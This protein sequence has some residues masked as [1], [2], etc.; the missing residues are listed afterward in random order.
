M[1]NGTVSRRT[2]RTQLA[3]Q[4]RPVRKR[5]RLELLEDR[6]LLAFTVN[7]TPYL[8]LGDAALTGYDAG[9]D[10]VEVLWQT[11]G[12]QDT[13]TFTAQVRH[14]GDLAW[15][16]VSLN[17]DIVTGVS[18]RINHS[19]TLSGL[20]FDDNYDYLVTH[21][22]GGSPIATYQSTFHT[23]KATTDFGDYTFVTYGDSANGD[24]PSNFIAVQTRIKALNPA[25][26]LLLG[27]NVYSSGTHA[28]YDLRLDPSK[29]AA[30]TTYNKNH[31]DYFAFGNHDVGAAN[32]QAAL[33][34]YSMPIP[35]AGVTSPAGITFDAN[36]QAEKNYSY[37]YGGVHFLTFDTNN[38][39][40][41]A[42]LDKQLDW[43]VADINAAKARSTPPNWIIVFG[44]HPITSLGGHTEHTPDDYYY[45]QVLSRLGPSGVGV[46]LLLFGHAH[47][48]QRSYP[49]TGHT[50]ATAT[51][52]L[53]TDNNYA[54]GAGLPLVVQGTGGAD[55]G[56]YGASDATF[57]G[58][59]VAKAL[60]SNT[61]VAVQFGF[62]KVDVTA[63]RLTY[64]YVN[65]AGVVLDSF[66]IGTPPP[67]TT[68]PTASLAHPQDNALTDQN[69]L[70]NQVTVNT[71]QSNFQIQLSDV[72]DGIDDATVLASAVTVTRNSLPLVAGTDYSFAY[73]TLTDLITLTPLAPVGS[74]FGSGNYTIAL[75]TAIED[76]ANHPLAA[77]TI[78]LLIDTSLPSVVKFQ[79]GVAGYN[80]TLDTYIGEVNAGVSFGASSRVN[81]DGDDDPL[82]NQS[83]AQ[84][85]QGLIRFNNLFTGPGPASSSRYG[86]PIP[87][88]ATIINA[89]LSVRTGTSSG[90]ISASLFN[91]HRMIATWDESSTWNSMS[92]SGVGIAR[93]NIEASS[94]IT[95]SAS[96]GNVNVAGGLVNFNVTT[97]VQYWSTNLAASTRGWLVHPDGVALGGNPVSGQTDGWWFDSSETNTIANRPYLTITFAV[98]PT[99]LSPGG[100]YTIAEGSPLTLSASATGTGPLTYSWD[101]NGDNAFG[102][103]VGSNP[104]LT[105][106][107]LIPLG[108]TDGPATRNVS[109]RVSDTY[110]HT[111]DSATTLLTIDNVAP[112]ADAGGP[113]TI[114]EGSSLNLNGTGS[115]PAGAADPLTY[116]WA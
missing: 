110:G 24:P 41:T 28:E 54:K 30:L 66:T 5:S 90:D 86:G 96:G 108:I 71:A 27:D 77:S 23:R 95:A 73:D 43:A 103:A 34:N 87:D 76:L 85:V 46:D 64:S 91:L 10:Q 12:T 2:C 113:Y 104:T 109:V 37:D 105:W 100:P 94:T 70:V 102:D 53:D 18:G 114:V 99:D 62:G 106:A 47:N 36:V 69:P 21:L 60:D 111:V 81:S 6:R 8:Q 38:W 25:F 101:I 29:N 42:A 9:A 58:T 97:D 48:Y 59:Y 74:K 15:T 65:T 75:S 39:T 89:T 51:Y 56:G 83:T 14:T 88:G 98:A 45:D 116:S 20:A 82:N 16:N 4:S 49:L 3:R 35:V 84:E 11:T 50:G 13:D 52:V 78:T 32:G 44:H 92:T 19:A 57:A 1:A 79:D 63:D 112:T 7:H 72:G 93:D 17:A 115:D 40:N 55:A 67:D 80:G 26:S 22:R 33:D 107:Q 68:P 31:I 61:S